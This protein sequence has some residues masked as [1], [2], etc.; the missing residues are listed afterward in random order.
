[1]KVNHTLEPIYD[2][3]SRVLILGSMPSIKSRKIGFYYA[4]PQN[5]FWKTLASVYQEEIGKT[6][7]DKIEFLRIHH[8]ALYDVLK[9]CDIS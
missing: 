4:H 5:R 1:M 6:I 9:S 3:N 7:K 8:I 2:K